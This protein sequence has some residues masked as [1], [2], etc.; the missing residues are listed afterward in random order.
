[1]S[2]SRG[3][4]GDTGWSAGVVG[5][6]HKKNKLR[7]GNNT[8]S[9]GYSANSSNIT[10]SS[11]WANDGGATLGHTHDRGRSGGGGSGSPRGRFVAGQVV[12]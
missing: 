5:R 8:S 12:I 2:S 10:I 9:S 6:R 1:M 11:P 4:A 3:R 7:R